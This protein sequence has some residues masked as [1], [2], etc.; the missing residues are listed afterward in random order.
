MQSIEIQL[1]SS[2]ASTNTMDMERITNIV[3]RVYKASEKGLWMH[4]AVRTSVEEMAEY[5]SNGEI[6]VA[7]S[8]GK[9]IGCVRV[10][11][12][13]EETGE[14]GMLAVDNQFQGGWHWTRVNPFC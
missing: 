8:M 2:N 4:G 3:N 6:A 5:T 14:F 7:R 12:L 1:L 10:R 9:I 11:R 13:D